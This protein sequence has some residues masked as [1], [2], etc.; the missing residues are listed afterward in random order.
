MLITSELHGTNLMAPAFYIAG[1]DVMAIGFNQR[2]DLYPDVQP[3]LKRA[4]LPLPAWH[5]LT[6]PPNRVPRFHRMGRNFNLPT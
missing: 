6:C 1:M 3:S 4:G 2:T 5:C